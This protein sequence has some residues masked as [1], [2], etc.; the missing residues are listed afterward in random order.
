VLL[1]SWTDGDAGSSSVRT[2]R[3]NIAGLIAGK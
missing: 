1:F 3:A 2:A